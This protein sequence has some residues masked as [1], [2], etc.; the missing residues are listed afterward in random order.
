MFF[1]RC[2]LVA[3]SR[4]VHRRYNSFIINVSNYVM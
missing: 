3:S 2:V 1:V 4:C